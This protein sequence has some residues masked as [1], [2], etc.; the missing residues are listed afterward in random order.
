MQKEPLITD[1]PNPEF[2]VKNEAHFFCTSNFSR[3][4][5]IGN[6]S[7]SEYQQYFVISQMFGVG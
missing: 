4:D 7:L 3:Q 5:D 6:H 2:F 1:G